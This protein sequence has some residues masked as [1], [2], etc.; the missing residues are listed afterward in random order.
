MDLESVTGNYW[1]E[2]TAAGAAANRAFAAGRASSDNNKQR[3][4]TQITKEREHKWNERGERG[5]KWF[6]RGA[7]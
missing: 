6:G 7:S 4:Q 2:E 3:L 5:A 1:A